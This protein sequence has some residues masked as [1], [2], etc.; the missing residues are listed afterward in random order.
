MKKNNQIVESL[1]DSSLLPEGV[2]EE[3]QNEAKEQR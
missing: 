2:S 3:I 1:K